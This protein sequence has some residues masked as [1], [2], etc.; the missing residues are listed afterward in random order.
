MRIAAV[1]FAALLA[2]T[3]L[4]AQAPERTPATVLPTIKPGRLLRI[5]AGNAL[6]AGKLDSLT[7][8][9]LVLNGVDGRSSIPIHTINT[10]WVRQ[11]R[12]AKGALIGGAIGAALTTAFLHIVVSGLCDSTDGCHRD[13]VRAWGYGIA[14]GG[15]GGA[16]IGA[17]V[18]SL[19]QGWDKRAP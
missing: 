2:S 16:L 18:G 19:V 10:V 6:M 14:I 17:G 5:E 1:V 7:T 13:H 8:D 4:V 15:A 9:R 12:G 3:R 11:G